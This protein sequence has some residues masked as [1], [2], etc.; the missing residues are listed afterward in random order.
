MWIKGQTAGTMPGYRSF[1]MGALSGLRGAVMLKGEE[2]EEVLSNRA[3]AQTEKHSAAASPSNHYRN[4]HDFW[5]GL[6]M[7][8]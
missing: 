6:A 7:P 8:R 5:M 2:M 1:E 4:W 3:G